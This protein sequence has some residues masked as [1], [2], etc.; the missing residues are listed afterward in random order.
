MKDYYDLWVISQTF[1]IDRARLAGA[2]SA[3]FVRRRTPIPD[4]VPDGLSRKFAEDVVKQQQ[5][6]A[7][8]R[9]L[10]VDP[11]PLGSVVEMLEAFLMPAAAAAHES[12]GPDGA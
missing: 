8:K 12:T 10:G 7:F 1:D 2:I 4:A 9:D 3:T 5:W 11:G 6:E